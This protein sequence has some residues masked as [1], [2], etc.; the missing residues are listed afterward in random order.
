VVVA[1]AVAAEVTVAAV[2]ASTLRGRPERIFIS[3]D[4][5]TGRST[6]SFQPPDIGTPIVHEDDH[7]GV[8]AL[9]DAKA[10]VDKNPGCTVHGPHFHAARPPGKSRFRK[11]PGPGA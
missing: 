11:R 3:V 7:K 8:R 4:E 5:S 10:I 9:A 6:T 2:V 1:V